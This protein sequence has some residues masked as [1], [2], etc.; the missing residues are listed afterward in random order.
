MSG[1]RDSAPLVVANQLSTRFASG[2][3]LLSRVGRKG[4][5]VT[6]V[7]CVDLAIARRQIVGLVGESGAGKTTLARTLLRLTAPSS[8]TLTFDG[9]DI[10]RIK[11]SALTRLRRDMQMVFQDAHGSLSPRLT[12]AEA[13]TEPYVIHRVPE[14]ERKPVQDL[15]ASV[16]LA[17]DIAQRYPHEISGGQAR[18]VGLARALA[19]EPAFIVA[20]EPTSGLDVSAASSVLNLLLELRDGLGLTY[21]VVTHNLNTVGY[22]ADVVAVMYLGELIEVGP[23]TAVLDA[24]THPYT[25]FLLAARPELGASRR[26]AAAPGEMPSPLRPPPGCRFH[27]RCPHATDICRIQRPISEVTDSGQTVRCHHWRAIAGREPSPM[28]V[29]GGDRG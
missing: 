7:D 27:T 9:A 25:Q 29:E 19:L 22:L 1:D 21:L 17:A 15:L 12:V 6:A 16:E 24:P 3:R 10:T 18:R 14:G 2:G 5:G 26:V 4:S 23:A 20:D 13:I 11:G 8:G 28:L